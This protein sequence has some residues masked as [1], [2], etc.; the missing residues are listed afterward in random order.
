MREDNLLCLRR[1][2][3][4]VTTNSNHG[5][6]VYPNLAGSMQL[7]GLDQLWIA[8][9][10]YIRLETEFVYLAVVLDAFSRRVIG[11]ALD[12]HLEDDLT[13]AALEMA[14]R[15]RTPSAGLMH[16]SDRDVSIRLARQHKFT[17]RERRA[18]QHEPQQKSLRQRHLRIIYEDSEIRRGL[19]P[20]IPR[21]DRGSILDRP[22][23]RENLQWQAPSLGPGLSPVDR[24]RTFLFACSFSTAGGHMKNEGALEMRFLRHGGIYRSDVSFLLVNP[25][26]VPP[27]VG[28]PRSQVIERDGRCTPCPSSATSSDR[29]FLDRDARQ[30]CPS[31]LH[32]HPQHKT[33]AGSN[34]TIYHRT[35]TLS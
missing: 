6:H 8:D 31:P 26:R 20:A 27:P 13:I 30:H 35:V 17:Q 23:H 21:S 3:F 2:K 16:H 19:P 34:G 14:L 32:R 12:R 18:D 9:I 25:G 22:L 5:L 28:R 29:L 1:R 4:V 11:W 7:T 10:T 24:V 33:I 15:R